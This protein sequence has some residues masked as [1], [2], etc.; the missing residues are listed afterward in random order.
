MIRFF[1]NR[2]MLL[3]YLKGT[4]VYAASLQIAMWIVVIC[5]LTGSVPALGVPDPIS[6]DLVYC[7]LQKAWVNRR[8]DAEPPETKYALDE[9][10]SPADQKRSFVAEASKHFLARQAGKDTE[11]AEKLYFNYLDKGRRAFTEINP[12]NNVP[13]QRLESSSVKQKSA[14]ANHS[15][16]FS[17]DLT[18]VF[19]LELFA[20]PPTG[21]RSSKFDSQ[22]SIKLE[23]ISRNINPRSPPFSI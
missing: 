16:D 6:P 15:A 18:E 17:Q 2:E 3:A 21:Y 4:K 22:I 7:P 13:E 20:R 14:G 5:V 12:L 9:I 1:C 8:G 23:T 10:C 19:S 11:G